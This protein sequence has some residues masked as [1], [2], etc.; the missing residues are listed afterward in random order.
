MSRFP[1]RALKAT[2]T[3]F[4]PVLARFLADLE[5]T[6][7]TEDVW[8]LIVG[9]STAYGLP[10]VDYVYATDYRNWERAQ[11]IRTTLPGEWLEEVQKRPLIR[12]TSVFRMHG[13]VHL[14]PV[15]IGSEFLPEIEPVS[16]D[17]RD[18]IMI[19]DAMGLKSGLAIPLR[20]G[21]PG[22]AGL[23]AFG[24]PHRRDK[25][26]SMLPEIGWVLHSAALSAHARY[27]ELF[28]LEFIGRNQLTPKHKE[29]IQLVGQ[30]LMDKEIAHILGITF[31]AVRQRL[32]AVQAKT[33]T[34]NRAEL[35]ALA[36][37][38]G[39]IDDPM[40]R[41]HEDDLTIFITTGDGTSGTELRRPTPGTEAAE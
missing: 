10:I 34:R 21:D 28:K 5:T 31:S 1:K 33:G 23:I 26:L 13:C 25:F 24:G 11:F 9:L 8:D 15:V 29:L 39:L 6:K 4:P 20:M 36:Q 30:G 14:T 27:T 12:H 38:V 3:F 37:R 7:T 2:E 40:L 16:D 22:Q 35:A 41:T 32:V 19:G 17:K 18:H